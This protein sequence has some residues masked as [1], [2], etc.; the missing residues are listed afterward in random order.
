[1]FAIN[2]ITSYDSFRNISTDNITAYKVI[3]ENK[4]KLLIS[5]SPSS[6]TII[7]L[8]YEGS[9]N[10]LEFPPIENFLTSFRL[11]NPLVS[12]GWKKKIGPN[13]WTPGILIFSG[14]PWAFWK[15]TKWPP[16]LSAMP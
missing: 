2:S 10:Q 6:T 14:R 7:T 8:Y 3:E 1:M 11:Y 9:S 15:A 13:A 16:R 4:E 5:D 12:E